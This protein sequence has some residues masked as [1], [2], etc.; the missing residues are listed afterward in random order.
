VTVVVDDH[1]LRDLVVGRPPE[2]LVAVAGGEYA[3]TNLYLYRLCRSA[4]ASP[5]AGRLLGGWSDAERVALMVRLVELPEEIRIVPMRT[6]AG[7]MAAIATAAGGL[8]TL[9]AEA[10][11]A[12]EHLGAGLCVAA[13]DDGP[14]LR[15]AARDLGLAHHAIDR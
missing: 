9:G 14:G 10:V 13:E 12:A 6:L 15:E 8:S 7:R 11:A 4:S 2:R 1:L 5:R 3:T